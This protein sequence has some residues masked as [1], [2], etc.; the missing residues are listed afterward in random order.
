MQEKPR[1]LK[2]R[3]KARADLL[4]IVA[5]IA[6]TS[7]ISAQEL[8]DEVEVKT[9]QLPGCP[10]LYKPSIRVRGMLEL[11][12]RDDT[13]VFY[14]ATSKLVEIVSVLHVRRKGGASKLSPP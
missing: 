12:V 8:K 6:E 5:S 14:R 13:A 7:P 9:A 4:E 2:W 3:P 11:L 1:L 10:E